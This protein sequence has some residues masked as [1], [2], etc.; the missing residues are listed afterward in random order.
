MSTS[1]IDHASFTTKKLVSML[2]EE[3]AMKLCAAC[4]FLWTGVSVVC[5]CV[6]IGVFVAMTLQKP[7]LTEVRSP[8]SQLPVVVAT[9]ENSAYVA[10]PLTLGPDVNKAQYMAYLTDDK[11]QV[12]YR[13]PQVVI[14]RPAQVI[15]AGGLSFK[16]P[17]LAPG[18]Y[19]LNAKIRYALNPL[20]EAT[21][22]ME[23]ARVLIK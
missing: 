10:S 7:T 9:P 20:K 17:Q 3:I 11:G 21:L 16:V 12:V 18:T 4:S 5:V 15:S 22:Q 1:K 19:F 8:R 6:I 14:D 23:L 13:Y 2:G